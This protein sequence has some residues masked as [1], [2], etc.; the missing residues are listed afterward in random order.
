[1][2]LI[3]NN[4]YK[5]FKISISHLLKIIETPDFQ[6]FKDDEHALDIYRYQKRYFSQY[7]NFNFHG[8]ISLGKIPESKKYQILDGQHRVF[9]MSKLFS[10]FCDFFVICHI[11]QKNTQD[12]LYEIYHTINQSKKV[13][14]Y[15]NRNEAEILKKTQEY[16]KSLF[17]P[18]I[19]NTKRPHAPNINL[20]IC[21]QHLKNSQ[22]I[23]RLQIQ[24]SDILIHYIIELNNYY[25]SLTLNDWK[26]WGFD[27]SKITDGKEKDNVVFCLGF[28]QEY[29]W[30]GKI[31]Q[32]YEKNIDYDNMSHNTI[33]NTQN[34]PK[35]T[36]EKLW[37][38]VFGDYMKGTCYCCEE[39]IEF[40]NFEMGHV[41]ARIYGGT[42]ELENLQ[43]I[44]GT[45][46]RDMGTMH[47]EE[48]KK[49]FS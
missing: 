40:G 6:R 11:Y 44:C 16:L 39:I 22:I 25:K 42:N 29:E 17:K 35:A 21:I 41:L 18:F 1:M 28:Y 33:K 4:S 27:I 36:K 15:K 14:L 31:L 23:S 34:I 37:K 30:I 48:Y 32:K 9:A 19:K 43:P 49:Q 38:K 24:T 2:E 26:K 8:V 10:E 45:C 47:M 7:Q 20:D 12:E 3:Y 46:N 13:E 5:I